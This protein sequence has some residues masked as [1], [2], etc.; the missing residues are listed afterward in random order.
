M[1][2]I[3]SGSADA[4]GSIAEI[5]GGKELNIQ[6]HFENDLQ[7]PKDVKAPTNYREAMEFAKNFTQV[8]SDSIF[9]DKRNQPVGLPCVI[10]LHLLELIKDDA[11]TL[12]NEISHSMA[13]ECVR[14]IQDYEKV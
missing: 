9:K 8:L 14:I 11:P 12:S 7:L 1:L 4:D 10:W 13:S 6:C 3:R 2:K 5:K